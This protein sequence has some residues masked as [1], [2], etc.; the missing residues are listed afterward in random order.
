[1]LGFSLDTSK[2][3]HLIFAE[4]Q[5]CNIFTCFFLLVKTDNQLSQEITFMVPQVRS[6]RCINAI[7]SFC[8]NPETAPLSR[9]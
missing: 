9:L 6:K 3:F 2:N 1:M 7:L 4:Q 5:N 8:C